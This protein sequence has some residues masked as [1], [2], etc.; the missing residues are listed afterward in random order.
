M[1][2]QQPPVPRLHSDVYPFI[3][4][5]KFRGSLQGKVALITGSAGAIGQAIAECFAVAGAK[6]VLVFNRTQPA[7]KEHF[8]GLGAAD[9]LAIQCNVAELSSCEEL[10]RQVCMPACVFRGSRRSSREGLL[11]VMGAFFK[12]LEAFGT[13]DILVNNAG[14]NGLEPTIAHSPSQPTYALFTILLPRLLPCQYMQ[15][16]SYAYPPINQYLNAHEQNRC[17]SSPPDSFIHDLSVNLHG[18]YYLMR[19]L[20]PGIRAQKSGCVLNITSRAGVLPN[21]PFSTSYHASKAALINLTGCVQA[22]VDVDGLEDVH[23]YALHPGGVRSEMTLNKYRNA[24]TTLPD[25]PAVAAKLTQRV[26]GYNDSPYLNGMTCV[27]L[28]T[29]IARQVLRGRYF[30]VGQ[31][32]EDVLASAGEAAIQ[33]DPELYTLHTRYLGTVPDSSGAVLDEPFAFPGF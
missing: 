13:V 32:L 33:A 20:M 26:D 25:H 14:A 19:L 24:E 7:A 28:A 23:L 16:V 29:G 11:M 6:L 8:T 2:S 15:T 3:Y 30:D 4:P 31:D 5:S 12:A 18:P 22:E 1:A 27:A 9:V 21:I 10:V 17:T